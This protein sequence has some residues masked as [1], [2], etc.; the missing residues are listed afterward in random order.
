MKSSKKYPRN[1]FKHKCSLV[2]KQ[3]QNKNIDKNY[4][5]KV[6]NDSYHMVGK[7][8]AIELLNRYRCRP[9]LAEDNILCYKIFSAINLKSY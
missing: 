7:I 3:S 2:F 4:Y 5:K 1:E 9:A 8:L 6:V